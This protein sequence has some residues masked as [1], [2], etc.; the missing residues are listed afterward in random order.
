MDLIWYALIGVGT[1]IAVVWLRSATDKKV[2]IT[3]ND[4]VIAAIAVVLALVIGGKI[5]KFGIGPSGV[6][7]ETTR[8]AIL[9][10]AEQPIIAQV[11]PL[12]VASVAEAAKG[13]VGDIPA[14]VRDRVQGLD[15]TLGFGGYA[16]WAIQ[17]YFN[18]LTPYDFFRYAIIL[19]P[20]GRLFGL[21]DARSLQGLPG[22]C[23]ADLV[24][25]LRRRPQRR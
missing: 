18:A 14:M 24:R 25:E 8:E 10:S 15:F 19:E 4:A 9:S 12:P 20:D 22:S 16:P 17:E 7:A 23:L 3:L 2:E 6:T 5:S 11:T 13:G 1:L 21:T